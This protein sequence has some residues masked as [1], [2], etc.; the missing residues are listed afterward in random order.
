MYRIVF[1]FDANNKIGYGHMIRCLAL[2]EKLRSLN[3][4][5]II[6]SREQLD[7]PYPIILIMTPFSAI[8]EKGYVYE[9]IENELLEMQ[10][11]LLKY[12]P[13]AIVVDHYGVTKNYFEGIRKY[14]KVIIGIDDCN[15]QFGE[16]LVDMIVNGNCYADVGFYKGSVA[17][18]LVGSKYTLLRKEFSDFE[19]RI[20]SIDVKTITI[21][22]G[23]ADPLDVT[24]FLVNLISKIDECKHI[25]KKIVIG[26]GFTD[27]NIIHI[28]K[29]VGNDESF[30][31]LYNARME[32]VMR[33]S[34]LFVVSSGS[35]MNEL[36]VTGTPSVSM[37]LSEDQVLVGE[38]FHKQKITKNLGWYNEITEKKLNRI[39]IEVIKN[40]SCRKEMIEKGQQ[41]ID[42]KGSQ[43]VAKEIISIIKEI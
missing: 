28:E 19:K 31:L 6:F 21:S 20:P 36:A 7:V 38:F 8:T 23:G 12:K 16:Y 2:A 22:T 27:E 3:C 10:G 34:D 26:N 9:N 42:G 30:E 18:K 43:R 17:R 33:A 1:R 4:E 24:A 40:F 37:I 25:N 32:E 13:D 39:L 14:V 29:C 41:L 5:I 11:L 35:T 15:M